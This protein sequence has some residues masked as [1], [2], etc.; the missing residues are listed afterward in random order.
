MIRK[1]L[2]ALG[3]HKWLMIIREEID[4]MGVYN[5]YSRCLHCP[6]DRTGYDFDEEAR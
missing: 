6:A 5:T 4:G 2:C 3:R 1:L